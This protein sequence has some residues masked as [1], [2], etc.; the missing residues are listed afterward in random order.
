MSEIKTQWN[1]HELLI[2]ERMALLVG[3]SHHYYNMLRY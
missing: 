3:Q 1:H 2:N